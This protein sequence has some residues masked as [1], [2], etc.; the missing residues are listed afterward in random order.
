MITR[1][2]HQIWVGGAPFPA[3]F[4]A[5]QESWRHHHPGWE[6]RLWTD[7]NLPGD[8]RWPEVYEP[9]RS[10]AER[11]DLIRLELLWR[12][13]GV[14]VDTD[15]ECL[16]PLEPL[17]AG[18]TL[19]VAEAKP[20]D[21]LNNALIAAVPRHPLIGRALDAAHVQ[22]PGEPF[23]KDAS[24][25]LML[26]RV[27]RAGEGLTVLAAPLVY[28]QGDE[29]RRDAYTIHHLARSWKDDDGWRSAALL[30]EKRL[31]R[32]RRAHAETR[33]E[34]EKLRERPG[35]PRLSLRTWARVGGVLAAARRPTR[36]SKTPSAPVARRLRPDADPNDGLRILF[37]LR[38]S[39]YGRVMENLLR[40]LLRRG[41]T[42][43][44]AVATE[45]RRAA[46]QSTLLDRLAAEHDGFT[47]G[48]LGARDAIWDRVAVP[49]RHALDYLR[50]LEP[51]YATA[52]PLR[53][54]A[55]ERTPTVVL[56]LLAFP[57]RGAAGRRL[58]GRA[59]GR[60]EAALPV[61]PALKSEIKRIRADVVLASPVVG[62]GSLESDHLRAAQR[63]GVPTVV[64]VASWDNLSNK[65][66]LR[67]VPTRTLVWNATQ[68]HEAVA[69]HGIP[70][71]QV[72]AVGAHSF[73]HWFDWAPTRSREEFAAQLGVDPQQRLVLYLGS[74]PFISGDETDFVRE[75]VGRLRADPRTRDTTVL[76]R[77]HPYNAA[78]WDGLDL[79]GAVVWP[80]AGQVPDDAAAK[81]DY[82]DSLYHSD[83]VVGIN[84]TALIEASILDRS[85]LTLVSD[86]HETQDGT[87]HF[88]YLVDDGEG[89]GP[90]SVARSWDEHLGQVAEAVGDPGARSASC[91]AFVDSFVR[92]HGRDEAAAPR[93][94]DAIEQVAATAVAKVPASAFSEWLK[95]APWVGVALL[96]VLAPHQT[97]RLVRKRIRRARK[98]LRRR[99]RARSPLL[100][101]LAEP[102]RELRQLRKTVRHEVK[103]LRRRVVAVHNMRNRRTYATSLAAIPARDE[104]PAV[105]NRRGLLG[106]GVEIGVKQG[107]FSELLLERWR[108]ARLVSVDPWLSVAW[109]EYVDRS[110]VSQDEFDENMEITR[111]RLHRFGARSE[112]LRKTSVEGAATFEDASLDFVYIDA[113]HDY[114][115][116]L[117]DLEAWFGKVRPGGIIAGHDYVDGDLPQGDFGVK[118]AV[119]E[120]FGARGLAVHSTDGPSA[121]EMFPS[122]IVEVPR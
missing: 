53:R 9:D 101:R 12:F 103:L 93:A 36:A 88:G 17:L 100:A 83:T 21:R 48:T 45:G 11:A 104:L 39:Q 89:T 28:P 90:V 8:L 92:P 13:G 82:Y 107:K 116:V 91:A 61:P 97:S 5:Y 78:G 31:E 49:L 7:E 114:A 24:G 99:L 84:T 30:A 57:F 51:E 80:A 4:A 85:V 46:K 59:L 58:V 40:E 115:S 47:W 72:E 109:E 79:E 16:R 26:D 6:L 64:P 38:A 105:L 95:E 119:D 96:A 55:R 3:E 65:G 33:R 43:H 120:F 29:Q 62:L 42:V 14:Y 2:I 22:T 111:R 63:L 113:R 73:D 44:V 15:M 118:S 112:I 110:N 70:R 54:R 1:T 20:G 117:E 50:Y 66:L 37:F 87:L 32:E 23:D 34:L 94:A 106:V 27:L 25:P 10:A 108:G 67:D 121:V 18:A 77:P 56:W 35:A 41:H 76:L 86:R 98:E 52:E 122:W 60:L 71:E 81:A 75:W 102:E 69:L 74:A 68:V 19:A